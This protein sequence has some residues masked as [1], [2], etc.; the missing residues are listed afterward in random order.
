M[1]GFDYDVPAVPFGQLDRLPAGLGRPRSRPVDL[2][3]RQ[4]RQASEL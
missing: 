1:A 3:R 4:V 2:C